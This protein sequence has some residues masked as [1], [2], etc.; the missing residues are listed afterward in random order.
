MEAVTSLGALRIERLWREVNRII[1]R[2]Y[3]NLFYYLG[4]ENLLDPLDDMH[5]CC[6]HTVF[7]WINHSLQVFVQQINNHPVKTGGNVH[8]WCTSRLSRLLLEDS[9]SQVVCVIRHD[10]SLI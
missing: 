2:P 10:L 4:G 7:L 1:C 8:K 6:L 9:E 3:R 5:L